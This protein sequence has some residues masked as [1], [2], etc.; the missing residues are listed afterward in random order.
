MKDD[1]KVKKPKVD[2]VSETKEVEKNAPDVSAAKDP[3][4]QK[5]EEVAEPT[6][7]VHPHSRQHI[8]SKILPDKKSY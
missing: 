6:D 8:A 1:E 3:N 4:E 7:Q 2:K 5:Q